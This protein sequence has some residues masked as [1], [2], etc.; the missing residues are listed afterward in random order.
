MKKLFTAFLC[1][2]VVAGCRITINDLQ[3]LWT[4]QSIRPLA[5]GVQNPWTSLLDTMDVRIYFSENGDLKIFFVKDGDVTFRL[6]SFILLEK[7]KQLDIRDTGIIFNPR[8]ELL[9]V[10]SLNKKE[11]QLEGRYY[12]HPIAPSAPEDSF[13]LAAWQLIR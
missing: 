13:L 9:D 6:G 11:L 7:E 4:L 3:G 2:L 10:I 8:G 1:L 12:V 5:S